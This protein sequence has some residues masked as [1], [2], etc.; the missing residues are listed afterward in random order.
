M[1]QESP[2]PEASACLGTDMAVSGLIAGVLTIRAL[3]FGVQSRVPDFWKLPY[4]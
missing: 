3:V 1:P 4:S 2:S